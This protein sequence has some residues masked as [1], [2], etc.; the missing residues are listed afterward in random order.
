MSLDKQEQIGAELFNLNNIKEVNAQNF[1]ESTP[2]VMWKQK[3]KAR[4]GRDSEKLMLSTLFEKLNAHDNGGVEALVA[5]VLTDPN[6]H[7]VGV[8][9]ENLLLQKWVDGARNNIHDDVR[10]FVRYA[11]YR[12]PARDAV[13]ASGQ[14]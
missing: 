5:Q 14:R 1:F 13:Y 12:G 11:L 4:F 9:Y 7:A 10:N 6:T 8:R 3:V 2:Y